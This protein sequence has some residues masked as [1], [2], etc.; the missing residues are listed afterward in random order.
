MGGEGTH[1]EAKVYKNSSASR[2][3]VKGILKAVL[4]IIDNSGIV[5]NIE[6][7]IISHLPVTNK[8]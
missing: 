7:F 6:Q 3:G 8:V 1:R 5:H 2:A 4:V